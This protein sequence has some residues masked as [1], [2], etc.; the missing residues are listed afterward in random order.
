[1]LKELMGNVPKCLQVKGMTVDLIVHRKF[2]NPYLL[3][4]ALL[5]LQISLSQAKPD[6]TILAKI[7]EKTIS[8]DE[9][10]QRCELTIRPNNF[11]SK[12][13]ALENLV[14][15]K[16]LALEAMQSTRLLENPAFQGRLRGIKEQLM[17]DKLFAR[18]AF[19]KV[20]LDSTEVKN[21]YELSVREYELEYYTISNPELAQ[22]IESAIHSAPEGADTVFKELEE[23]VGKRPIRKVRYEDQDDEVIHEALFSKRLDLG[24]VVGPLKLSDGSYL[25]MKVLNWVDYPLISGVDQQVRWKK[26]QD[27]LRQAEARRL[28]HSFQ[29]GVMYQKKIEFD[30]QS[31]DIL[32]GWALRKHL[33]N[34]GKN[35]SL[36]SRATDFS[37]SG[38]QIDQNAP[39]FTLDNKLWTVGDF[40]KE[41]MAHPLVYRTTNIDSSNFREQFKLAIID[42]MRDHYVTQ[43]AY[44][45]SLDESEDV[46]RTVEMWRDAF[47]AVDQEKA[48]IKSAL[49]KGLIHENDAPGIRKYWISSLRALQKKYGGMVQINHDEFDEI[50]LTNIDLFAWRPG[51]PYPVV[52]PQFPVFISSGKLDDLTPSLTLP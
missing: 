1:V 11:K 24:T 4:P 10:V 32:A 27:G 44:R 52:V 6:D 5:S 23:T 15:E 26:V 16:I 43:E 31:F 42:M 36:R 39:F 2:L 34:D 47:L 20:Q 8:V 12:N 7:G 25:L 51:V 37:S 9:F 33:A 29:A 49:E 21:A 18:E 19:D 41:L 50:S 38:P 45:R 40:E 3:F 17:R 46:Y 22:R 14:S 13:T 30:R 28:W 48:I 35:D